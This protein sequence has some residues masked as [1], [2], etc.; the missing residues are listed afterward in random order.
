MN[1]FAAVMLSVLTAGV[2]ATNASHA[3]GT[4]DFTQITAPTAADAGHSL[5]VEG[6][7]S[8]VRIEAHGATITEVL[9][10]LGTTFDVRYRSSITLNEALNGT[11]SGSLPE[12]ISRV[13]RSYNYAIEYEDSEVEVI[14]LAKRGGLTAAP[15]PPPI[16]FRHGRCACPPSW[17][18]TFATRLA[19]QSR[20][21]CAS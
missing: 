17:P 15:A 3:Q 8:A 6:D 16:P 19:R 1:R 10:A 4:V 7:T 12:V 2:F 9:L 18:P 5:H 14:I 20:C 11:Y 21:A 13:L